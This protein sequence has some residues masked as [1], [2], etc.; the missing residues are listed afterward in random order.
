MG[1]FSNGTEGDCYE[2]QYCSRCAHRDGPDGDGG[3]M[4]WFAHMMK[5]YEECNK[6]DSILHMLIPRLKDGS[7][8]GKCA[9]FIDKVLYRAL[10]EQAP[11]EREGSIEVAVR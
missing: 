9:M 6:P 8:N 11:G 7:G 2:A 1:Y 4:V 3:C 5:N 10:T